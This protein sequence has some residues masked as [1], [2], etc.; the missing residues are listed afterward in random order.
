MGKKAAAT[1]SS[2]NGSATAA[3][4]ASDLY[5]LVHAFL[6]ISGMKKAAV[7]LEKEAKLVRSFGLKRCVAFRHWRC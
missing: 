2:I 4:V 5:P 3:P 1:T 7:A 6:S